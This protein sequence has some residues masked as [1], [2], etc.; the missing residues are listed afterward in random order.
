MRRGHREQLL[1]EGGLECVLK[2]GVDQAQPA[3]AD[4]PQLLSCSRP[5]CH[6]HSRAVSP[7]DLSIVHDEIEAKGRSGKG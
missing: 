7:Q 5:S 6:P 2:C 3:I 1:V 4:V